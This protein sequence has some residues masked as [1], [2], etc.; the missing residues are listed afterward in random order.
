ML[1]EIKGTRTRFEKTC[2]GPVLQI[3]TCVE[4]NFLEQMSSYKVWACC[5]TKGK[6]YSMYIY[7]YIY[8]YIDTI[9]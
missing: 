3:R 5:K 1:T 4:V 6:E 7:I 9:K 2:L 8:I